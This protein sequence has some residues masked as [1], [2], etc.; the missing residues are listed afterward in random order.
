MKRRRLSIW[1]ALLAML[2]ALIPTA[3]S[4]HAA[5]APEVIELAPWRAEAPLPE[6][7]RQPKRPDQETKRFPPQLRAA[8]A[9]P[10]P[11]ATS[12]LK[13]LD[14]AAGDEIS[15]A[16]RSD[17]T[18]WAWGQFDS[19]ELGRGDSEY[20]WEYSVPVRVRGLP[21]IAQIAA[22]GEHAIALA[23][24]G[25]V[26]EFGRK[27][28]E[29]TGG[30][31]AKVPG[32]SN[33]KAVAAGDGH[34]LA[35][36]KSGTVYAWGENGA[37][38]LG[39]GTT[40]DRTEAV[41]VEGLTSVTAIAAGLGE[42]LAVA[43]GNLWVWGGSW[44]NVHPEKVTAFAGLGTVRDVA[45]ASDEAVVVTSAKAYRWSLLR[46][47]TPPE[48]VPG[49]AGVTA[50]EGAPHN[51]YLK[52]ATGEWLGWGDN[53][54][55]QLGNGTTDD[56][57]DAPVSLGKHEH[58]AGGYYHTLLQ[59]AAGVKASGSNF[60]GQLGT[61]TADDALTHVPT[62]SMLVDTEAPQWDDWASLDLRATGSP[63]NTTLIVT[64]WP[65]DI[66][67]TDEVA[68]YRVYLDGVKVAEVEGNRQFA[69]VPNFD[70]AT[71]HTVT[72]K[73]GDPSGNWSEALE[74]QW[75][76]FP[77]LSSRSAESYAI[78]LFY[79]RPLQE[80]PPAAAD[81]HY[82]INGE[83]QGTADE[84]RYSAS[85]GYIGL[86]LPDVIMPDDT[87]TL[88]YTGPELYDLNGTALATMTET[89]IWNRTYDSGSDPY[90]GSAETSSDGQWLFLHFNRFMDRDAVPAGA[91]FTVKINGVV[92]A[93]PKVLE[94]LER[95]V[96]LELDKPVRAGDVVTLSYTPGAT[97]LLDVYGR[98]VSAF[99]N[100]F[101]ENQAA[102][103]KM[104]PYL[105]R[106]AVSDEN[107]LL[108][109]SEDLS[110]AS[111]PAASSFKVSV[112]GGTG[113]SPE[114][115][116]IDQSAVRLTLGKP[117]AP[118]DVLTVTYKPGTKP[119]KDPAGN[120]VA[121]FTNRPV[122]NLTSAVELLDAM[123]D[124]NTLTL[125]YA[126]PLNTASVPDKTAYTVKLGAQASKAP[127]KVAIE[128][129]AVILTL[130]TRAKEGPGRPRVQVADN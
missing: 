20:A 3:P 114:A 81:F 87:V 65:D 115:V 62:V 26:W 63:G 130:A 40:E 56:A 13:M 49:S 78:D 104:P 95:I 27:R 35:L 2:L 12:K 85:N 69:L 22:S 75:F 109:F 51:Y 111:V 47:G 59:D 16:L 15:V 80:T 73:A 64:W 14:V 39:D 91:D 102:P 97:P 101:V 70:T 57:V 45:V 94:V 24:D 117:A 30:A 53:E 33:V 107:L 8:T 67:E 112:N 123:V 124:G 43:G 19:E 119:L 61:G 129:D 121:A 71:A 90:L 5:P 29:W 11:A 25:T 105:L 34:G 103:D 116:S 93:Q 21:P 125:T 66:Y 7:P 42:S 127:T 1:P 82:T 17:G 99:S 32:L 68:A 58:L 128:G 106:A 23:T 108:Q 18:V 6:V 83:K 86:I 126:E 28:F 38:Q 84:I 100:R 96:Y 37:G 77:F 50:V 48:E 55:G 41:K 120:A 88:S 118:G 113:V 72:V 54:W 46:L 92:Q 36:T 31:P 9:S 110:P 44:L 60:N 4:A 76:D 89:R 52:S 98:Q 74:G 122:E 10:A 79:D